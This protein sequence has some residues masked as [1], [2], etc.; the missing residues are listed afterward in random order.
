[1]NYKHWRYTQECIQC[2][3][4]YGL[5]YVIRSKIAIIISPIHRVLNCTTDES[6]SW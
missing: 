4:D 2:I 3:R 1:M 6:S 5:L